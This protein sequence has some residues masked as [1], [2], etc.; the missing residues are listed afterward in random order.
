VA[1]CSTRVSRFVSV[2]RAARG[3]VRWVA[4][5]LIAACLA[6]VIAGLVD[7]ARARLGIVG[8]PAVAGFAALLAVPACL[9]GALLLRGLWAA[10]R[11]RRL[12]P[13]LIEEGGGAPRLAAWMAFLL[14]GAFLLSWTTFNATRIVSRLTTFKV[15][16]VALAL[17]GV[18]VVAALILA[19]LS[20]PSV[21]V[22]AAGLRALDAR[23]RPRLGRSVLAPRLLLAATL[24]LAIGLVLA[25]WYVSIRPRVG[26]LDT[27]ILLHPV[28]AIAITAIVHPL[29]R[30]MSVRTARWTLSAPTLA[31]TV[32]IAVAAIAVR[33]AAPSKMLSIWAQPTIAGLAVETVFDVDALR[34]AATLEKYRPMPRPGAPHRDIVLV[35]IDTVRYD[36]TPLGGGTAAMPTLAGLARRGAVFDRAIAPSNVT[37]R[38]M[39]A[40]ML[41]AS[42]PRVRGR[43]VGWALR[44][45]PRHVP[46]AERLLVAGYDTAG[47]FCCG[48]FW[49]PT[50]RTGYSRG[51]QHVTID[52]DGD[53]I[54]GHAVEW[55]RK[56]YGAPQQR[57]AFTWLHFIEPHNWMK[58][59]DGGTVSTAKDSKTRRYDKALSE[60]DEY[61]KELVAAIDAIPEARRPILVITSDHGEGL[62]DHGSPYHSSDLYD[63][64]VHVPLVVVGPGITPHRVA[65]TVSLT[66]LAP[67]LL[68]LAGFLPPRMPDMDGRSI[69]D[70]VTGARVPDGDGGYAFAAMIQDRSTSES[71]RAVVRGR[72]KLIDGPRGVELY[73]VRAD[74]GEVRDVA[75]AEPQVRG[76]LQ[77]LMEQRAAID[78]RPPF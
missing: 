33:V 16:V 51:L 14:I 63:T 69:A 44:L 53:V 32:A 70:L 5:S 75:G 19:A 24:A 4:P 9:G 66:D 20:R 34:S 28:L 54:T 61:L 59:K 22:L 6:A 8:V 36:H 26:A 1:E 21:D 13:T 37:R 57:P 2:V 76:E 42:P 68:D 27:R 40:I 46:L 58:R 23:V 77:R 49:D 50:K 78:A 30:R 12:A 18:V 3:A 11:P 45:D 52:P 7:G 41:G 10:W 74:P 62:G 38:S 47:F 35:T 55:L 39:P 43:V 25:G 71:A 56:R 29:R 64:Q 17:P 48:S 65:E 72:W 73:D 67:T 60:V 31:G 15:D